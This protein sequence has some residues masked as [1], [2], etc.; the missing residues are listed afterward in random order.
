[1]TPS[2]GASSP[3]VLS[4]RTESTVRSLSL[5]VIAAFVV[6]AGSF[7]AAILVSQHSASDIR[8]VV[9]EI[10]Q[11][12][13]PSVATLSEARHELWQLEGQL[14]H[15]RDDLASGRPADT[16]PAEA[17]FARFQGELASYRVLPAFP[18]E[19]AIRERVEA[20]F[21]RTVAATTHAL[22]AA[23]RSDSVALTAS[24]NQEVPAAFE[25]MAAV[26]RELIQF[27]LKEGQA[28][29]LRVEEVRRSS[30]R[31]AIG[32]GS[33]ALVLTLVLAAVLA[34]AMTRLAR[35]QAERIRAGSQERQELA[36]RLR[37]AEHL[38]ALGQIVAEVAHELGTP[39]NVISGR[40]ALLRQE[41][42][43]SPDAVAT[44]DAISEQSRR[45]TRIIQRL[46]ELSRERMPTLTT[47]SVAGIIRSTLDFLGPEIAT[48]G[49]SIR[50]EGAESVTAQADGD[51][52]QQVL[53]NV[54]RNAIQACPRGSTI[55]IRW[56]VVEDLELDIIDDGPGVSPELAER[57][58]QPFATTKPPGK[59]TGL[60]LAISLALMRQM[61]GSLRQIPGASRGAH[62]RAT[63]PTE[64]PLPGL[65]A[66]ARRA[67]GDSSGI[68][69]GDST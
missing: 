1:L 61:G 44:I 28:S 39:L 63:L 53:L 35:L 15:V 24:L 42:E 23:R 54:L 66:A 6:I 19:P 32:L 29:A 55:T 58:F 43:G 45:I 37:R 47:V 64:R 40:A 20:A 4:G 22:E 16:A 57:L 69:I 5:P 36:N 2:P 8:T 33:I 59:G 13:T 48:A 7:T 26:L 41:L 21:T 62:F 68:E 67:L 46:L 51:L 31:M 50:T 17:S 49:L 65:E 60:G 52:L 56:K 27:N 38:A 3:E 9:D 18:D 34:R 10:T 12:A 11:N 25:Q 14:G 30:A